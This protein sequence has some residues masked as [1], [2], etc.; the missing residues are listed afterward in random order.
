[1]KILAIL[2]A[3][4]VIGGCSKYSNLEAGDGWYQG[5]VDGDTGPDTVIIIRLIDPDPNQPN[6]RWHVTEHYVTGF[7][8]MERIT[9]QRTQGGEYRLA[10]L[11][12]SLKTFCDRFY[13]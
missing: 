1:V 10:D 3:L 9:M 5:I 4:A 11:P 7:P 13:R 12:D 2:F 6:S 8:P